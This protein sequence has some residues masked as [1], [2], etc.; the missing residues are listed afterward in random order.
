MTPCGPVAP[1]GPMI[2]C[3]PVAPVAPVRPKFPC[4]PV[5]PVN[6]VGPITPCGPVEPVAP[7][8]PVGPAEPAF[9]TLIPALT[10]TTSDRVT[11][12]ANSFLNEILKP[13]VT[14]KTAEPNI[15]PFFIPLPAV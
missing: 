15:S 11:S 8:G 14:V 12:V 10:G 4:G 6:P 7:V 9:N 2:P 5:A 1:V 3:G 13:A